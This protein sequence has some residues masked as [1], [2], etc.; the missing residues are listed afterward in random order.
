ML[1]RVLADLTVL[2][3]LTWILF[4]VV[5]GIWGRRRRLV[6]AAHLGGLGF[7]VVMQ[8]RG[9]YCPLTHIE[10]WLR[11]K[12]TGRTYAGSFIAH[13]AERLVYVELSP[14]LIFALTLVLVVFNVWLYIWGRKPGAGK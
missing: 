8:I 2:L 7:A 11:Q 9:W 12:G 13:Y 3:H 4:L 1:Y 6:R 10:V 14:G 5:G